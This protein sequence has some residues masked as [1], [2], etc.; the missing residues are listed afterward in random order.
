MIVKLCVFILKETAGMLRRMADSDICR[1]L[2]TVLERVA[3]TSKSRP[4]VSVKRRLY[5]GTC[6]TNFKRNWCELGENTTLQ[7]FVFFS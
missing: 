4:S 2:K 1:A 3:S 7:M 5:Q 6:R